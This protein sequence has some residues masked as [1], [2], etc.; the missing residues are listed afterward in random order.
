LKTKPDVTPVGCATVAIEDS[1]PEVR[2]I[3]AIPTSDREAI[4]KA[5]EAWPLED[6]VALAQTILQHSATYTASGA[7]TPQ[8]PSWKQMAGIASNGPTPP[9]DEEVAQWLDA[10]RSAK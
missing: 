6:Q 5:I 10:H 7:K 3:M 8:R 4:L 2:G 1:Y 9:S